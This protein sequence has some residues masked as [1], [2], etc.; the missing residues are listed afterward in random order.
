MRHP[1]VGRLG[2]AAGLLLLAACSDSPVEPGPPLESAGAPRLSASE[3][4]F[5]S[6]RV[7]YRA[8]TTPHATGRA[9]SA[10]LSVRALLGKDG[11][12]L[13]EATT[14]VLDQPGAPG[15]LASVQV[16]FYD[17]RGTGLAAP[18]ASFT[19]LD[20]GGTWSHTF[21]ER[22]RH[23]PLQ[24]Q[25][26]VRGIDGNRTGVVTLQDS[27]RLRP[28]LAVTDVAAPDVAAPG[29]PVLV[30]A[31][32][33]ELN[34]DVGATADCVLYVDGVEEDRA[35]GVW[36]ADGD[37]VVCAFAK[38]FTAPGRHTLTVRA[39][40]VRPG[41][42]DDANNGRSAEI[43]I[44]ATVGGFMEATDNSS[45]RSWSGS[46]T[47]QGYNL[48]GS[49]WRESR[50]SARADDVQSRS[51][52]LHVETD[53]RWAF[54]LT[55]HSVHGTDGAVLEDRTWILSGDGSGATTECGNHWEPGY[56]V[57]ACSAPNRTT[58]EIR[59]WAGYA[60]YYGREYWSRYHCD[61]GCD[62][63]DGYY[64]EWTGSGYSGAGGARYGQTVSWALEMTPE[65][66]PAYEVATSLTLFTTYTYWSRTP[67]ECYGS[68]LFTDCYSSTVSD[69]FRAGRVEL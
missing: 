62:T 55:L 36:V 1:T 68:A 9:G 43:E 52:L 49:M 65:G 45:Y 27:V 48:D 14:G 4:P 37:D 66:G 16:K 18:A 47:G 29:Q 26:T 61:P 57:W 67:W 21:A 30:H 40:G 59:R 60:Y 19:R 11:G 28:D 33:H 35:A 8:Q 32:L 2:A 46:V 56:V 51:A 20:D 15:Q 41:D 53:V 34:G 58:V 7:R 23:Q 13:V 69:Q 38:T 64:R 25:A 31:T 42:W 24:L 39:E 3:A 12:T 22:G 6:N 10:T 17:A 44:R 50:G 54:P 63:T 5:V